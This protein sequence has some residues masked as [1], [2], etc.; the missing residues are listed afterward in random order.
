MTDSEMNTCIDVGVDLWL[1]MEAACCVDY[2]DCPHEVCFA[3][4]AIGRGIAKLVLLRGL[5]LTDPVAKHA[6]E[7]LHKQ[8]RGESPLT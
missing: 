8:V 3:R 1:S 7:L 5:K 4:W 2:P 6:N